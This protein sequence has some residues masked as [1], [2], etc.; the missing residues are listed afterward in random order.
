MRFLAMFVAAFALAALATAGFIWFARS[1][2]EEPKRVLTFEI[3]P[4]RLHVAADYVSTR[5]RGEDGSGGP[6]F[7]AFLPDFQPAGRFDDVN[8]HTDAGDR[9]QRLVFIAPRPA[10]P[11]LDPAE[12]TGRLYERFLSQTSW[13]HPGGLTARVF[14]DGSPFEGDELYYVA[15]EGREF[16]ARC[17]RPDPSRKTPNTCLSVVR[18]GKLDVEIRFTASQLGD[19]QATVAGARGF[20]EAARR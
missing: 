6:V 8:A 18:M 19:W 17:R 11:T 20:I 15:P 4:E 3:G 13:S 7:A 12:R 5:A 1:P 9:F 16:A 14:E 10:D 2:G